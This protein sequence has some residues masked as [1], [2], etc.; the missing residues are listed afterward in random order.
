MLQKVAMLQNNS[1]DI[2]ISTLSHIFSKCEEKILTD[3]YNQSFLSQVLLSADLLV[4]NPCDKLA[5]NKVDKLETTIK[6]NNTLFEGGTKP[7]NKMKE[8]LK[9]L[10]KLN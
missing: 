3:N 7:K 9:R 4:S 5:Q 10:Y 1:I 6:I 2:S 8:K